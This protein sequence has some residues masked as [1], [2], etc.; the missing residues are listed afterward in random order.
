MS[1]SNV[2]TVQGLVPSVTSVDVAK[3]GLEAGWKQTY[4]KPLWGE[5]LGFTIKK[6]KAL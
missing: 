6:K 3:S 5:V 4:T 1:Y 2:F